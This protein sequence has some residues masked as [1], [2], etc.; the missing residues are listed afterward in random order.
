MKDS[1]NSAIETKPLSISDRVLL[2]ILARQAID[3]VVHNRPLE[4]LKI[5]DLPASLRQERAS[6]VTLTLHGQL[7]GCMGAIEPQQPLA[8]DVRQ[9]AISSAFHDPRFSPVQ[10]D[11]LPDIEIEISCLSPIQPLEYESPEE[12]ISALRPGIDGVLLRE[13]NLRAT[14]LPQVWEKIPDTEQFLSLLCQKMGVAPD[15][16]RTN[17]LDVSVYQV[18]E[19]R[20]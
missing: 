20:E 3:D 11:E 16:W 2:L 17:K 8:E 19:F 15:Y 4:K 1:K 5:K 13:G 6:F 10:S 18:E 7:R 12:L 14:F 9:Q